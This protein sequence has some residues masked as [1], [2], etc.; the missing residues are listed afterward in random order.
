MRM[1]IKLSRGQWPGWVTAL[2][3]SRE[4]P[5][6]LVLPDR[7]RRPGETV[8]ARAWFSRRVSGLVDGGVW[9]STA[10]GRHA[11]THA[12][13]ARLPAADRRTILEVGASDGV[14]SLELIYALDGRF[15]RLWVTDRTLCVRHAR[16]GDR[17]YFYD[18]DGRCLLVST[19]RFLAY[20]SAGGWPPFGGWARRIVAF[21][22]EAS[23][24]DLAEL[25][26]VQPDLRALAAQDARI[27]IRAYDATRPWDGGAVDLIKVANLFNRAYFAPDVIGRMLATLADALPEGARL[28]VIDNRGGRE[29]ASVLRRT[30]RGFALD[31]RVGDGAEVTALAVGLD[32]PAPAAAGGAR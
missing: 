3:P 28:V 23:A 9:R 6:D 29:S 11:R 20:A 7:C 21:A 15:D 25:D 14:T 1:P 12:L 30:A 10:P 2:L 27:L 31:E 16:R 17:V 18:E 26:L 8:A 13:I 22:P 24:A 4:D 19:G 32:L 5:A